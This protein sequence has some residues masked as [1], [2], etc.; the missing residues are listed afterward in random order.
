MILRAFYQNPLC[1]H[2]LY[3][4]TRNLIAGGSEATENNTKIETCRANL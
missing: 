3:M 2:V 1:E 4:K